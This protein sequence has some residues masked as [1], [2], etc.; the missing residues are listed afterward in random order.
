MKP[1]LS[2]LFDTNKIIDAFGK[3]GLGSAGS[4]FIEYMASFVEQ[5][6]R[7]MRNG[8]T[9]S[10]NIDCT[11]KTITLAHDVPQIVELGTTRN[12]TGVF[13]TR[14]VSQSNMLSAF[15]WYFSNTGEFTVRAKF[16]PTPTA[17]LDVQIIILF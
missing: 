10:D 7:G 9:F 14:V 6:L 11:I 2:R 4:D 16:D 8:F 15:N 12:P 3:I 1:T 17:R 5:T 13:V